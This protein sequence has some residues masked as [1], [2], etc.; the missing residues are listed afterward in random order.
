MRTYQLNQSPQGIFR[1]DLSAKRIFGLSREVLP[2]SSTPHI[3]PIHEIHP[4]TF[5]V[6]S[7]I[8]DLTNDWD[9]DPGFASY[10]FVTRSI[11][12]QLMH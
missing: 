2:S 1:E 3:L 11:R 9:H 4:C 7:R 8:S 6:S 5:T 10:A 12:C